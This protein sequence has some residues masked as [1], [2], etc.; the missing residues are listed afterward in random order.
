MRAY[1][2]YDLH[3]HPCREK[4]NVQD[5]GL[6]LYRSMMHPG[7]SHVAF[8]GAEVS[9]MHHPLH[10][11]GLRRLLPQHTACCSMYSSSCLLHRPHSARV[12][13]VL[14]DGSLSFHHA[15]AV[16]SQITVSLLLACLCFYVF[17]HCWPSCPQVNTTNNILTHALQSEWLVAVLHGRIRLPAPAAM[18]ADIE[19]QK[20]WKRSVIPAHSHRASALSLYTQAYH[21]QLVQDLG[22]TIRRKRWHLIDECFEPYTPADYADLMGCGGKDEA[23]EQRSHDASASKRQR[24]RGDAGY[25]AGMVADAEAPLSTT[26]VGTARS[27]PTVHG[28][29]GGRPRR[30]KWVM[31]T[32]GGGCCVLLLLYLIYHTLLPLHSGLRQRSRGGHTANHV[33]QPKTSLQQGWQDS[34]AQLLYAPVSSFLDALCRSRNRGSEYQVSCDWTMCQLKCT[35]QHC[36]AGLCCLGIS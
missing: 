12:L 17:Q 29:N 6:Y 16:L 33:V 2:G 27:T 31:A 25:V 21:D 8:V 15:L 1:L 9:H 20:Q 26:S 34:R 22:Q 7:I 30:S 24:A 36:L 10:D 19:A 28:S 4:L 5:D 35:L 14:A 18:V 23:Y 11:H 13:A 32:W 3:V